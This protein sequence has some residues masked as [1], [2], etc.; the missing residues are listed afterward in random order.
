MPR[1]P[2]LSRDIQPLSEFRASTAKFVRQVQETGRPL[3]LTQH[4][5][6]AAVLL[7]ISEYEKL[8]ERS[9]LVEDIRTAKHSWNGRGRRSRDC[10]EDRPQEASKVIVRWS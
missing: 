9:E 7:D 1:S 4:G 5:R 8:V 10:Q 3:V 2:K 6:R